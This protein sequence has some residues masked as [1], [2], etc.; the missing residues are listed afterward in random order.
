MQKTNKFSQNISEQREG[1]TEL[2]KNTIRKGK[3]HS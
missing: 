3:V 1:T 2:E